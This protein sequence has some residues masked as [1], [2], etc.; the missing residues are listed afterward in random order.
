[1]SEASM[2]NSE[3]EIEIALTVNGKSVAVRAKSTAR[4]LDVLR[5]QLSLTGTKEVC[6]EGECGACTVL[7]DGRAVN[8]CLV[9][10]AEAE[11]AEVTTIEGLEHPVL[12]AL[13][14]THAVQCGYC[15][16]GMALSAAAL[17]DEGGP[18]SEQE[19]KAGLAGNLCRCTGYAKIIEAVRLASM[20]TGREKS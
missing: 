7:L 19:I 1:M 17:I 10:A 18:L 8:S 2:Y 11:G 9:L 20:A 13:E 4:L 15:F 3:D 6:S 5:E 16:P 14:Q 12:K